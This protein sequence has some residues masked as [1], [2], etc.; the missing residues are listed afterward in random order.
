MINTKEKS[1][2]R[3]SLKKILVTICLIATTFITA[4]AAQNTSSKT[5]GSYKMIWCDVVS[6]SGLFNFDPDLGTETIDDSSVHELYTY[7]NYRALDE[8]EVVSQRTKTSSATYVLM[9][10]SNFADDA[11]VVTFVHRIYDNSTGLAKI[12]KVVVMD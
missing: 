6:W 2:M 8:G 11:E 9:E 5:S 3:N 10:V 1:V 12:S 4:Y 7:V